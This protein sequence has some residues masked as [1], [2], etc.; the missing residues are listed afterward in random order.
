MRRRWLG[1]AL[2][3]AA[4]AGCATL[5]PWDTSGLY[6][7]PP[8]DQS[9][10][11]VNPLTDF[12]LRCLYTAAQEVEAGKPLSEYEE[13]QLG[14]RDVSGFLHWECIGGLPQCPRVVVSNGRPSAE[15]RLYYV[16]GDERVTQRYVVCLLRN[17]Y[18][19]PQTVSR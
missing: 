15:G 14:G 1:A 2:I 18:S 11:P 5:G 3:A 8:A 13:A 16:H 10:A 4:F 7:E 12:L 17:G 9:T 19:W 6:L